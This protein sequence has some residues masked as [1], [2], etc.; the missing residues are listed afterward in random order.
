MGKTNNQTPS[1]KPSVSRAT[2]KPVTTTGV[3]AKAPTRKPT[4]T[5]KGQGSF[6]VLGAPTSK[7]NF[8]M[9]KNLI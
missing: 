4:L 5:K 9:Y 1:P 6:S 3:T 2:K 8:K 7:V